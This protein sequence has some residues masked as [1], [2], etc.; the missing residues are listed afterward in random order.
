[1][2]DKTAKNIARNFKSFICEVCKH[3]FKYK[4]RLVVHKRVHT[5]V[6][7]YKCDTCDKNFFVKSNLTRHMLIHRGKKERLS[8]SCLWKL[9]HSER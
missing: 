4:S 6:K 2:N 9:F 3:N 1:M 7:P 5:C 8:M